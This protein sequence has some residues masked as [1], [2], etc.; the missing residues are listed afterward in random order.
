MTHT[1]DELKLELDELKQLSEISLIPRNKIKLNQAIESVSAEIQD[2][3]VLCEVCTKRISPVVLFFKSNITQV[4]ASARLAETT[5]AFPLEGEEDEKSMTNKIDNHY[6]A[7]NVGYKQVGSFSWDAGSYDSPFVTVY[8][9]L[10]GTIYCYSI[11]K[12]WRVLLPVS[13]GHCGRGAVVRICKC[14]VVEKSGTPVALLCRAFST[15][16][17]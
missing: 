17:W 14:S 8:I 6:P 13:T 2:L 16:K 12:A 10:E 3:E 7:A 9:P 15:P 1:L 11:Q 4:I 5:A